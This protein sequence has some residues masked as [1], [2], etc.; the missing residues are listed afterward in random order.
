MFGWS[1]VK[2]FFLSNSME[3]GWIELKTIFGLEI[4][5]KAVYRQTK[6]MS[7]SDRSIFTEA[8]FLHSSLQA[9]GLLFI[10]APQVSN[11]DFLTTLISIL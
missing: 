11:F 7:L 1:F 8:E 10:F 9:F 4:K 3:M 5:K 2:C 6:S